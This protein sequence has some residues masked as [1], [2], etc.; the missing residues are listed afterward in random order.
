MRER[1]KEISA[2]VVRQLVENGCT[3]ATAESCTGGSIAA[4]ITGV[5]GCSAVFRG[6]VVAYSNEVKTTVLAVCEDTLV[7]H[8]AVSEEVVR[9][10]AQGAQ[11]IMNAHCAIA[12]SGIAGPGGGT[13]EKP[14]GTVWL[15]VAVGKTVFTR[16]MLSDDKG[17]EVNIEN[18][19]FCALTFLRSCLA[20]AERK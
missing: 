4:S 16:L 17:R 11:H 19:V 14:V 20:A 7:A 3:L 18:T 15:A 12:T 9:Q 2:A 10:M 8:G 6:G 1:I 5:A 13:P